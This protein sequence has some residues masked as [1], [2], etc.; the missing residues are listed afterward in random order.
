MYVTTRMM[1]NLDI[2]L[3][4]VYVNFNHPFEEYQSFSD[5]KLM[6]HAEF[7]YDSKTL[8]IFKNRYDLELTDELLQKINDLMLIDEL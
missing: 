3:N 4:R 5:I 2:N 6:Q 7:V 8:Q 1:V